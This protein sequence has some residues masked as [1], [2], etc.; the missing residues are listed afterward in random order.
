MFLGAIWF[1]G[2]YIYERLE[3]YVVTNRRVIYKEGI[4][5]RDVVFFPLERIQTVD[6][7]QSVLG[8][9]LNYGNVIVHT[10][11]TTH[12][13]TARAFINNP[14]EWRRQIFRAIESAPSLSTRSLR[15]SASKS[16]DASQISGDRLRELGQL[17]KDGLISREEY[18]K[19]RKELVSKL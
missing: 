5:R 15:E 9:L 10:A 13:T 8:R 17:H 19:K 16:S 11:A 3:E 4:I 7:R 2:I 1:L 6:V 18:E 14:E 12:G